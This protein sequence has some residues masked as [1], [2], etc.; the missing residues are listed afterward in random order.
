MGVF[1]PCPGLKCQN[2]SSYG[3][4]GDP[5]L[6][7]HSFQD[8]KPEILSCASISSRAPSSSAAAG[9][10]VATGEGITSETSG[11]SGNYSGDAGIPTG[12]SEVWTGKHTGVSASS[13]SNEEGDSAIASVNLAEY[14]GYRVGCIRT[15]IRADSGDSGWG[16][17]VSEGASNGSDS[18]SGAV[19]DVMVYVSVEADEEDIDM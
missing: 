2:Q 1:V 5:S 4:Y 8:P 19:V 6:I 17:S 12:N 16:T 18:L 13:E 14:L 10:V 9:V 15:A 7:L 3:T 11:D